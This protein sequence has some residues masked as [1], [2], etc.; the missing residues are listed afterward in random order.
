M[1]RIYLKTLRES[2]DLSLEE[3][4]SLS[5]VSYNYIL[6]IENGHQGDQASFMMM[7]RLARAYGI[8]LED[9]YRY[10]YQYLLKKGK[11]RLND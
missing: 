7:A 5:E 11:I 6:N 2:Q 4:A 1:K 10:E 3:M 9:L 8:T